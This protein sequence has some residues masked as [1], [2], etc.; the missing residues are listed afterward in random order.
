VD[1]DPLVALRDSTHVQ[2]MNA[3]GRLS[4]LFIPPVEAQVSSLAV[5]RVPRSAAASSRASARPPPPL[6]APPRL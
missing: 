4:F 5:P 6:P 3:N 1:V 2:L